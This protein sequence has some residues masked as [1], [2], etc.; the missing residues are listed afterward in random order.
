LVN[1]GLIFEQQGETASAQKIYQTGQS[2]CPG[3]SEFADRLAVLS[4][5]PKPGFKAGSYTL[6]DVDDLKLIR[7][8][9]E[10]FANDYVAAVP[11]L[12]TRCLGI[13]ENGK[14]FKTLSTFPKSYFKP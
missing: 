3:A 11:E 4:G 6:I 8:P 9:P 7:P 1:I 10:T 14:D 5:H 13:E 12:P 2:K